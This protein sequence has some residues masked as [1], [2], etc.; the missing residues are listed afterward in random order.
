ME[1]R[2][3]PGPF[4]TNII[5]RIDFASP[6]TEIALKLP[7]EFSKKAF[8]SFPILEPKNVVPTHMLLSPEG[9]EQTQIQKEWNFFSKNREKQLTITGETLFISYN[10]YETFE[11]LKNEFLKLVET[12]Y[13]AHSDLI[14]RRFGLRYINNIKL[15]ELD[16]T[17]WARYINGNLL[18]MFSF[19]ENQEII[20][21]A[22]NNMS[23]NYDNFNLN[24]HYGMYNPDYPASIREK[25][26]ILDF[27]AFQQ[28]PQDFN[29]LKGNIEMFHEKIQELFESCITNDLRTK[30]GL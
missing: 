1:E 11:Q 3:Y 9:K 22:F 25:V 30:M 23:F 20:S 26:F 24:F 13:G 2:K 8:E 15:D 14:V 19:S 4:L 5:V 16:F 7:N 18:C 12:L 17:N 28:G 29:D 6:I 21:R 27:D 10:K